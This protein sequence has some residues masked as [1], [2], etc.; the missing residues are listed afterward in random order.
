M[1]LDRFPRY[2]LA[3][4]PTPLEPPERLRRLLGGPRLD[5]KRE[6][7]IGG[8]EDPQARVPHRRRPED[9]RMNGTVR[10]NILLRK[11]ASTVHKRFTRLE[12]GRASCRERVE[13][14]EVGSRA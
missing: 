1:V 5:I 11:Y 7:C 3:H 10:T 8:K 2:P 4:A 6:D 14:T 9:G 12:I 13:T